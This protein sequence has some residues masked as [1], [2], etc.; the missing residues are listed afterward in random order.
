MKITVD[1]AVDKGGIKSYC[2]ILRAKG[3]L[4]NMSKSTKTKNTKTKK[5]SLSSYKFKTSDYV[6]MKSGTRRDANS[7]R[8]ISSD[9]NK[10]L[11]T[12]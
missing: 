3:E 1:K 5:P 12:T 7:G 9:T 8:L 10:K 6:I 11:V 2:R 4:M